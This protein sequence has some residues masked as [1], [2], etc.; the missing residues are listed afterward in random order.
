[1]YKKFTTTALIILFLSSAVLSYSQSLKTGQYYIL[2]LKGTVVNNALSN[3]PQFA[4]FDFQFKKTEDGNYVLEGYARDADKQPL[5][6]AISLI[7]VTR[8]VMPMTNQPF[9]KLI[10]EN[11][12]KIHLRLYKD[13]MAAY[14]VDGSEDYVL[15]PRKCRDRSGRLVNAVSYR[16]NTRIDDDNSDGSIESLTAV[17]PFNLN[18]SP[19]Y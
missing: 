9:R 18:P 6:T 14:N 13:T 12:E 10:N 16:F 8:S 7:P 1:M 17:K 5:G 11:I 19:P 2:M 15:T 3:Y 4:Y